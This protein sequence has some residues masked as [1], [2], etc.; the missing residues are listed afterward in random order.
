MNKN[1]NN[2]RNFLVHLSIE[3]G[4]LVHGVL[5]FD[6]QIIVIVFIIEQIIH[7]SLPS[8]FLIDWVGANVSTTKNV[9][10][11][12]VAI[13]HRTTHKEPSFRTQNVAECAENY[14]SRYSLCDV[15]HT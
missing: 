2:F 10:S 6:L 4:P 5:V 9:V 14:I 3:W 13:C 15:Y 1:V 7:P 8:N 12:S 11:D